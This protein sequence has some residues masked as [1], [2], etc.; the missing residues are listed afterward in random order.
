MRRAGE[1]Q[2]GFRRNEK[3]MLG[4]KLTGL[5]AGGKGWDEEEEDKVLTGFAPEQLRT[6]G[7][8]VLSPGAVFILA[9]PIAF[10]RRRQVAGPCGWGSS[11][12]RW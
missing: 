5:L 6:K 2:R 9:S 12:V 4:N 10:F 1:K 7:D 3:S 11:S 8:V